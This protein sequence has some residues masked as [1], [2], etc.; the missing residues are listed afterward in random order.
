MDEA[1]LVARLRA[2]DE[3]AFRVVVSRY[4]TS[5]LR[6]AQTMVPTRAVAEEVVQDTWLGLV[7]GW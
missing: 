6:L 7:R 5:L 1:D 2:G 3:E 4:H